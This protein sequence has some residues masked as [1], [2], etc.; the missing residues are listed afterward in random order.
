MRTLGVILCTLLWSGFSAPP[1]GATVHYSNGSAASVQA[2]HNAALNGD[3][4]IVPAGTFTWSTPVTISKAITVKGQAIGVTVIRDAV[5]SGPLMAWNLV[6]DQASRM[7]GIEFHDGGR[8]TTEFNGIIAVNAQAYDNRTMRIDHCKFDHLN[9]VNV[10]TRDV[11]GV[12]DHN[13]VR[14]RGKE[15]IQVWHP[16]WNGG[17]NGDRSWTD[18]NHFG[19]SQFTFI[20]DNQFIYDSDYGAIDAYAGAR[21]VARYNTFVRCSQGGHGTDSSGR[22]RSERAVESYNNTFIGDGN[23]GAIVYSRGG[24]TIIHDNTVTNGSRGLSRAFRLACYRTF[25]GFPLWGQANGRSAWDV[26]QPG[27]PFYVGTATSDGAQTVTVS[28]ATW[29]P[30]QWVGYSIVKTSNLVRGEQSTSLITANTSNTIAYQNSGAFGSNLG[31]VSGDTFELYKV[32]HAI[33]QPGRSGGSLITGNP[34]LRPAG[35][36]NQVTDPCYE[37][38]NIDM[39]NGETVYLHFVA[40]PQMRINEHYFNSTP[41]PGYTPY[42]YPHPLTGAAEASATDFNGDGSPDYVLYDPDTRQTVV[43]YMDN[44]VHVTGSYGPTPPAGWSLVAVADFNRDGH[45]DYVLLNPTTGQTVIWY[46]S[47]TRFLTANHGPTLPNGWELVATRDFNRDGHPDFV[48][49]NVSTGQSVIWYMNNNVHVTGSYGPT[50]PARWSLE[51]VADFNGDGH[52]DYVLFNADTGDSVIWYLSG[53]THTSGRYGPTIPTG[54]DFVGAADFDGNGRPD[55]VL[56][57]S[58]TRETATWY[59]NNYVLVGTADGPTLPG[60]WSLVAP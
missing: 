8:A 2:L 53:T 38:N 13:I 46:L 10:L 16:K 24:V 3:T 57:N 29:T 43:W 33:D 20:E 39:S 23:S 11:L 35:W 50:L 25:W 47:G 40:S 27:G 21:Y 28:G 9:G 59:M 15:F 36:N 22:L 1:S 31:F 18:T 5:Q 48:L 49:Y 55:Y 17:A 60:G 34:P 32:I 30:G 54:Y 19:S 44:N 4:I 58:S 51:A 56:Y 42:I 26:N 7:T 6:A 41:A 12:I 45:P 52:P 37:W 14:A